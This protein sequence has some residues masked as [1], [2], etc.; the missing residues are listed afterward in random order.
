MAKVTL[1]VE[2]GGSGRRLPLSLSFSESITSLGAESM[3]GSQA[4]WQDWAVKPWPLLTQYVQGQ[5][6]R[7]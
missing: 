3:S 6:P 1:L 2:S 7:P 4:G 5:V